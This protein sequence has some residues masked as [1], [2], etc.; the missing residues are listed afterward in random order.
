MVLCMVEPWL[1]TVPRFIYSAIW[2]D[3]PIDRSPI[4]RKSVKTCFSPHSRRNS[5]SVSSD[6]FF[7]LSRPFQN[8][9]RNSKIPTTSRV[10]VENVSVFRTKKVRLNV[11]FTPFPS[12]LVLGVCRQAFRLIKTFSEPSKKIK[13]L[14]II[15]V[16]VKNVNFFEPKMCLNVDFTSFPSEFRCLRILYYLAIYL[17][18]LWLDN[19]CIIYIYSKKHTSR[20][21]CKWI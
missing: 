13:V 5:W 7:A 1:Y 4:D 9:R 8:C 6:G 10:I 11:F 15:R 2:G 16:R 17:S 19:I 12:E 18:L 20:I 3:G 14:T 21:V